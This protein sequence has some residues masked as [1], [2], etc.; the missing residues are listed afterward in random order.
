MERSRAQGRLISVCGT[1]EITEYSV[2]VYKCKII[3]KRRNVLNEPSSPK[4]RVNTLERINI[5]LQQN[6]LKYIV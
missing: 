6:D 4:L 5:I 2:F 3:I 1:R